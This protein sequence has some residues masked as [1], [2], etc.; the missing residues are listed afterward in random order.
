MNGELLWSLVVPGYLG[1]LGFKAS[2][3]QSK[4]FSF[5]QSSFRDIHEIS[6]GDLLWVLGVT[7]NPVVNGVPGISYPR[8][9]LSK[10]V[11]NI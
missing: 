1:F 11:K 6:Y 4:F 3:F 9:I 2:L 8:I 5:H 7:W 10:V